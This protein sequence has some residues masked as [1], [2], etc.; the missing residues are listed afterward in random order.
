MTD[1]AFTAMALEE[2]EAA[3]ARGE[4]PAGGA[5]LA[6]SGNRIIERREPTVHVRMLVLSEGAR[7]VDRKVQ[8]WC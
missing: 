8:T 5:L 3:A 2:A 4:V 7:S 1:D 6:R